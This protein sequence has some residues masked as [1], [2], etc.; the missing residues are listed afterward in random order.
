MMDDTP[1]L[2]YCSGSPDH[3]ITDPESSADHTVYYRGWGDE[4]SPGMGQGTMVAK[5]YEGTTLR[6]TDPTTRTLGTSVTEYNFTLS[7]AE[8]NSI[9]DYNILRLEIDAK[10]PSMGGPIQYCSWAYFSCPDAPSPPP[11]ATQNGSAFM[12]FLD[13]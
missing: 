6:A 12:L 10:D 5:L 2:F 7:T 3:T 9:T 13:T 1:A 11:A 8:A 4:G